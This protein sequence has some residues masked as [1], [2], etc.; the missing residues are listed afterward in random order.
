[1]A[2]VADRANP[3]RIRSCEKLIA[4]GEIAL[5]LK[6]VHVLVEKALLSHETVLEALRCHISMRQGLPASA[7]PSG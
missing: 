5:M 6:P 3:H 4:M 1:M 7:L 2:L